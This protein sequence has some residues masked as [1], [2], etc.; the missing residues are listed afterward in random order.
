VQQPVLKKDRKEFHLG[1]LSY[2][3]LTLLG[4]CEVFFF[5]TLMQLPPNERATQIG[6]MILGL[7]GLLGG[8]LGISII[9]KK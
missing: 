2:A 6:G 7:L 5:E 1:G 9:G 3:F 8:G 4:I